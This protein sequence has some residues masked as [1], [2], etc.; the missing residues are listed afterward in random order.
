MTIEDLMLSAPTCPS[1]D[2]SENSLSL[3]EIDERDGA[4]VL[5]SFVPNADGGFNIVSLQ[6]G[7]EDGC[8]SDMRFVQ[9]IT[10]NDGVKN[11]ILSEEEFATRFALNFIC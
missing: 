2:D 10:Y 9:E 7:L 5:F 4:S 1:D 11:H 8:N 6:D 3:V